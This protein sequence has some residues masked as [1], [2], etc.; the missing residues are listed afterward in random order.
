M[1]TLWHV[2][3]H[4]IDLYVEHEVIKECE[5]ENVKSN[6]KNNAKKATDPP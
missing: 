6:D 1:W 5:M 4:D 2:T 3:M